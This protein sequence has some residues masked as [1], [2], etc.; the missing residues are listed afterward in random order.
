MARKMTLS[1]MRIIAGSVANGRSCGHAENSLLASASTIA[2]YA[3]SRR[4]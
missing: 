1:V 3:A 2:S 4:P